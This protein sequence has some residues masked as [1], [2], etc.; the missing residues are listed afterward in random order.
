MKK[1]SSLAGREVRDGRRQ[2]SEV[3]RERIVQAMLEL[4]GTGDVCPSA[5]EVAARAEVGLRTV[6]RHFENMESLYQEINAAIFAEVHPI[7]TRPFAGVNWQSQIAELIDRRVRIYERIMPYKIAGDI[8]RHQS[9]FL[10]SQPGKLMHEQRAILSGLLPAEKR[11]DVL[12]FE[13]LD[14]ILS[15]DTWRRLRKEQKLSVLRSRQV[16]EHLVSLMVAG[17]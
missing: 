9:A 2:R 5:E 15:F 8:H 1:I 3:S 4:V 12:L 7:M 11:N 10:A 6:F 14:L 13:S 16:I 17:N